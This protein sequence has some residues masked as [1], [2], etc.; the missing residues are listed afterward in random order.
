M[1]D[2]HTNVLVRMTIEMKTQLQTESGLHDCS[3]T[4]E[5]TNRL[6]ASLSPAPGIAPALLTNTLPASYTNPIA[7][8]IVECN[9]KGPANYL[10]SGIDQAMLDVFRNLPPEKQLALLSLFR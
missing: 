1:A 3:L 5:I 6:Q 9:E 10:I 2:T 8:H 7:Q 4:K